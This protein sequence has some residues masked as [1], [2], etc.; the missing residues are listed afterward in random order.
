MPSRRLRATTTPTGPRRWRSS[1]MTPSSAP[2]SAFDSLTHVEL[3]RCRYFNVFVVRRNS[4]AATDEERLR[5]L[6][7]GE[8]HAGEFINRFRHGS[9]V[10][11]LADN[12]DTHGAGAPLLYGGV[13]GAIGVIAPLNAEQ[14]D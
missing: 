8:F 11:R 10:M 12:A 9:L 1:T 4:E 13:S 5:L 7:V 6:T 2:S 14:Y 3:T